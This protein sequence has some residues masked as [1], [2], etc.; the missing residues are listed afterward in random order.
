LIKTGR[1]HVWHHSQS[2]STISTITPKTGANL[3][4]RQTASPKTDG[5]LKVLGQSKFPSLRSS[6]GSPGSKNGSAGS[7]SGDSTNSGTPKNMLDFP[8][9]LTPKFSIEEPSYPPPSLIQLLSDG[10]APSSAEYQ[11]PSSP[12]PSFGYSAPSRPRQVTAATAAD[13][14]SIKEP[15]MDPPSI[16]LET[17]SS[18]QNQMFNRII[19]GNDSSLAAG[20]GGG[21]GSGGG[22]S[23]VKDDDDST[24]QVPSGDQSAVISS[25][26]TN[27]RGSKS[28][29]SSYLRG[30]VR[31]KRVELYVE[32]SLS[33]FEVWK[34]TYVW[35]SVELCC[36]QL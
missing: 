9:N 3:L 20:G 25:I 5:L 13:S 4:I 32:E 21:G 35:L 23:L 7:K 2:A 30:S 17:S 12:P 24:S 1:V 36:L 19:N 8:T 14:I 31:A 6:A 27:R 22:G 29:G 15:S 33:S 11:E 18:T 26:V 34:Y 16:V 28:N 10:K